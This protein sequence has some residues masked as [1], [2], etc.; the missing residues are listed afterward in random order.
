MFIDTHCHLTDLKISGRLDFAVKDYLAAGVK[1]VINV[2]CSARTSL[3]AK[4]QAHLYE[5]VFFAAGV[6]PSDCGDYCARAEETVLKLA[7]DEKCV[8]IGEIGLDYYW[9]PFDRER[10][11]ECFAR[12]IE[13]AYSK[14]LPVSLH[15]REAMG[16]AIEILSANR[17]KLVYGG[18]MHCY[19]GSKESAATLLDMGLYIAFGGTLTFKNARNVP[20]VAEFVPTDRILTETDSPYLAPEGLRGTVNEPKNIPVIAE[21]LAAIKGIETERLAEAVKI[22]AETLFPKLA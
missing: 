6:H 17:S 8:A 12:Q 5:S 15:V 3:L 20:E 4:E 10:Q 1:K 7:D 22:N 19:S 18:V 2:G 9:K 21:R 14:K 16:E 13:I 11:R